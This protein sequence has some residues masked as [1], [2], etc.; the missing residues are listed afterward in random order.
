MLAKIGIIYL[1]IKEAIYISWIAFK[2]Y[3][4]WIKK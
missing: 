3:L 1:I 2:C 4:R